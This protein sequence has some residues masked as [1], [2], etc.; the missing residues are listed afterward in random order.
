MGAAR[1]CH[2]VGVLTSAG[3]SSPIGGVSPDARSGDA[4]VV[5]PAPRPQPLDLS[6]L[7]FSPST[8]APPRPPW[9]AALAF[10]ARSA[11]PDC[12]G[13]AG[14]RCCRMV[15]PADRAAPAGRDA[16]AAPP[17]RAQHPQP[18]V[19]H[20]HDRRLHPTPQ[21]PPSSTASDGP[22]RSPR[23]ATTC[24]AVVGLTCPK[25]LA[26]GATTPIGRPLDRSSDSALSNPARPDAP[27][28]AARP[29]RGHQ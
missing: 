13:R 14:R 19:H 26:L 6:P 25:R 18:P 7:N 29:C 12:R 17:P 28:P 3:A 27:A 22:S 16:P 1:R 2:P 4:R 20:G 8:S 21:G 15:G 23:P 5:S 10:A 9:R 24:A 11:Q